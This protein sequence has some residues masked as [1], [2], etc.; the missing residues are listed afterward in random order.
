MKAAGT[1]TFVLDA[2]VTLAWCFADES[3]DD[4]EQILDM[5][6]SGSNAVVPAIWPVEVANALLVAERRK[7]ITLAQVTSL[8][9]RIGLLPILVEPTLTERTFV[10]VLNSARREQLS[11]YDGSYLELAMREGL[12]LAT[13]DQSLKRSA[14]NSGVVL[15]LN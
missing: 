3:T 5:L 6:S 2:S 13:M 11:A 15:L 12:P 10:A 4:T 14:K 1:K 9:G 8:L 7:R